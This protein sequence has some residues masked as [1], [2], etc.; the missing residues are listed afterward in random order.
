[1]QANFLGFGM[2]GPMATKDVVNGVLVAAFR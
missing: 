1:M 2:T